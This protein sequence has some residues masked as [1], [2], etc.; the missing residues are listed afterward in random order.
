MAKA[1]KNGKT[2]VYIVPSVYSILESG[3]MNKDDYR[4]EFL[5]RMKV[6]YQH[7]KDDDK[8]FHAI[9]TMKTKT[10]IYMFKDLRDAQDFLRTGLVPTSSFGEVK[11]MEL[12]EYQKYMSGE[13][14]WRPCEDGDCLMDDAGGPWKNLC[15]ECKDAGHIDSH[16]CD[17]DKSLKEE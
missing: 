3:C 12:S 11:V 14:E 2:N 7:S 4:D 6:K 16:I 8:W 5:A 13:A 1:E 10:N 17:I 9:R 15:S